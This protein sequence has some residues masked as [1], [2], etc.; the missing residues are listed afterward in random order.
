MNQLT[1]T[2]KKAI[3]TTIALVALTIGIYKYQ[4]PTGNNGLYGKIGTWIQTPAGRLAQAKKIAGLG[5]NDYACYGISDYLISH[6]DWVADFNLQCRRVGIKDLSL[7]YSKSS[8]VVNDL[9]YFLKQCKNDSM[10]F[11]STTSEIE[12]YNTGDR[13][14]FYRDIRTVGNYDHSHNLLS[15]FYQGWNNQQDADSMVR[16]G[17]GVWLHSYVNMSKD[18][19]TGANLFGY[20]K[21]RL[22]MY[23]NS[24][25]NPLINPG[26][27]KFY[28][29]VL[30]SNENPDPAKTQFGYKYYKTHKPTDAI[31]S[32]Q[33][34]WTFHATADMKTWLVN[35]GGQLFYEKFLP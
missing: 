16:N 14:G 15:W 18:T 1:T 17:D 25:K 24:C 32:F 19:A 5:F 20:Q 30:T 22:I 34:Y 26:K 6:W 29:R 28:H 10:K 9:D 33:N 21:T 23:A 3:A 13:A 27:K 2:T 8:T 12:Q 4:T 7:I 11:S 31:N 35:S